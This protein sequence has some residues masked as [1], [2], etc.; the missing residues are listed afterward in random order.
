MKKR[1]IV[2]FMVLLVGLLSGCY[3]EAV[4]QFGVWYCEEAEIQISMDKGT[5]SFVTVDGEQHLCDTDHDRGSS[6]LML[7]VQIPFGKYSLDEI[8]FEG[9]C[10]YF[11]EK[12]MI[13]RAD[14]TDYVFTRMDRSIA[15]TE[16]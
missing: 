8:M 9:D 16:K 13:I 1:V 12:I 5:P 7:F 4:P 11:D 6:W 2:L 3:R 15:G 14:Q 10:V